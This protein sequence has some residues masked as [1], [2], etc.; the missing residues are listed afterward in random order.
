MVFHQGFPEVRQ[1]LARRFAELEG[2]RKL[3][4]LMQRNELA[5]LGADKWLILLV[6]NTDLR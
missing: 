4:E 1:G 5:W 2:F 6:G 3:L